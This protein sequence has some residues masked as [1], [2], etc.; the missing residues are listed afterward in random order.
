MTHLTLDQW[1]REQ[2]RK[3]RRLRRLNNGKWWCIFCE[4]HPKWAGTIVAEFMCTD[5]PGAVVDRQPHRI[6]MRL[7]FFRSSRG[8][9]LLENPTHLKLNH[10]RDKWDELVQQGFRWH[11]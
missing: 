6:T 4:D 1:H 9:E 5:V 2:G 7:S 8:G 11:D 10:M 3:E